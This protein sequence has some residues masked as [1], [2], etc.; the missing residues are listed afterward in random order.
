MSRK[1]S[2]KAFVMYLALKKHKEPNPISEKVTN[3]TLIN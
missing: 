3:K 1:K 2:E